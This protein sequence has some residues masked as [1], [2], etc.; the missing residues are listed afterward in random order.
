MSVFRVYSGAVGPLEEFWGA[1]LVG[2]QFAT[3]F[4][5]TKRTS[6]NAKPKEFFDNLIAKVIDL[7]CRV[8][9]NPTT[10][11]A[12]AEFP[13][14]YRLTGGNKEVFYTVP[15][16]PP[17]EHKLKL[18][19]EQDD[20]TDKKVSMAVPSRPVRFNDDYLTR[21]VGMFMNPALSTDDKQKFLLGLLL[22]KR[23]R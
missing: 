12:G 15:G 18:V 1:A 13:V 6:P 11:P 3:V 19:A 9:Y 4:N 10:N 21:A 14:G 8:T 17:Q 16:R 20:P 7:N 2:D 23:C 22:L 5:D